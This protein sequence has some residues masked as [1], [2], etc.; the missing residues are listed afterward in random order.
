MADLDLIYESHAR[1]QMA[2]RL[3]SEAE[4]N[5]TVN[6]PDRIRPARRLRTR[7]PCTIYERQFGD[8]RCKVYVRLGTSP[9]VIATVA[10]HG[11]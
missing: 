11:E 9:P 6:S 1:E 3:L 2:E 10:W 4:V 8:R 7:P 5:A